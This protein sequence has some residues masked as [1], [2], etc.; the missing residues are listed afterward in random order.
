MTEWGR[1]ETYTEKREA[2]PIRIEVTDELGQTKKTEYDYTPDTD[3]PWVFD[4]VSEVREYDLKKPT[5]AGGGLLRRTVNGYQ[6]LGYRYPNFAT[7]GD[8]RNYPVWVNLVTSVDV[9]AP[10][11]RR[12]SRT[13]YRYDEGSFGGSTDTYTGSL[14]NTPGVVHHSVSYDP[15]WWGNWI[16]RMGFVVTARGNL[17]S[18]TTYADAVNLTGALTQRRV[19]DITG[20]L[21]AIST[22]CAGATACQQTTYQYTDATQ[23]TY[24]TKRIVGSADQN[25]A[26]SAV[27]NKVYDF[28]TGLELSTTDA[29]GRTSVAEYAPDTWRPTKTTSATGAYTTFAFDDPGLSLTETTYTNDG[30]IAAKNIKTLNGRGQPRREEV[31]AGTDAQTGQELWNVVAV[32]FDKLGR[33]WRRSQPYR[34]GDSANT[35]QWNETV[36]DALGRTRKQIAPDGSVNETIYNEAA[37]PQGAAADAGQTIKVIDPWNRERWGRTNADGRLVE[38]V[39]PDPNGNGTVATGG[40]LTQYRYDLLGN[41]LEVTQGAQH[42]VFDYDSFGR[43]VRQ[44][45]AEAAATLDNLG[46]LAAPGTGT[47]SDVFTYD[48]RSNM[49]THVD[50]RGV[51]ATFTYALGTQ[52]DPLNRLS[53]VTYDTQGAANVAP[54]PQVNFSYMPTGDVTRLQ[55]MTT[56]GVSLEEFD[57]DS[58]KRISE[59]KLTFLNRQAYPL[60]TKYLYDSLNRLTYIYYP[61][62]YGQTG[63]PQKVV[64]QSYDA[65]SR[66]SSL[67]VNEEKYASQIT[68]NAASQATSLKVG[69]DGANQLTENYSYDPVTGLLAQQTLVRGTDVTHPLLNLS[70]DYAGANGKQTGQLT[71]V[72]NNLDHNRDRAYKYDPLGRLSQAAGGANTLWTETYSYDRYGN[73]LGVAAFGSTAQLTAPAEP[74]NLLPTDQLARNVTPETAELPW[75]DSRDARTVTDVPAGLK[76]GPAP[77]AVANAGAAPTSAAL[78]EATGQL[79]GNWRFDEGMGLSTADTSGGAHNGTLQNAAWAVGKTGPGAINF[80]GTN[81][82]V[83]MGAPASLNMT[84]GMT[85]GAWIYPTGSGSDSYWGGII[86]NKEGEYEITRAADGTIRWALANSN[87]GWTWINTG[88]VAPLNQWTHIT[89][90][91][92]QGAVSTYANGALVHSYAGAGAIGDVDGSQNNFRVGGRQAVPQYFQGRIDEVRVYGR[93]LTPSEVATLPNAPAQAGG[94]RTNFAAATAG[95]VAT[96][97]NFTQEGVYSG[98]H[99]QPAYAN[100]GLRYI[101]PPGGDHYWR[102]EHGLPTWVQ[103]D[104]GGGAKTIDEVDIFTVADYP[105]FLTQADPDPTQTF[106]QYGT[107]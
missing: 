102:D 88:Y 49:A 106:T 104:F 73:R 77:V 26:T 40:L 30:I 85:L 69:P 76:L 81:S 80:N 46:N 51:K 87:P 75:A 94:T 82:Y 56:A 8:G 2:R 43:L 70:Y 62:Q 4:Q 93:A 59:K 3:N 68:Y 1:N 60:T 37:R 6:N 90:V 17:T 65:A 21:V 95:A 23:Y 14:V 66:I 48:D 7:D 42:R 44:K 10:D 91:Y 97:Q 39:E 55:S 71:R 45:T 41:L 57:Y 20:N 47:W 78:V 34:R 99:F 27:V 63:T 19:Y 92:D 61:N 86:I 72:L 25:A 107:T 31:L 15:Y 32:Q 22:D 105:A 50:A 67:L 13:E 64:R 100:D 28:N 98:L 38:V 52:P 11:N 79:V 35:V 53:Q 58:E 18:I 89:V 36:Y 16:L 101:N 103:I 9:Y 33:L 12:L 54:A 84:T 74:K 5:G 29:N 83:D 24:P 96:A